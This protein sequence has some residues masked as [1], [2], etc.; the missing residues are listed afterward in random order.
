MPRK[1]KP[2][3]PP[4]RALGHPQAMVPPQLSPEEE[5]VLILIGHC[6]PGVP[7]IASP[8]GLAEFTNTALKG[9]CFTVSEKVALSATCWPPW[10]MQDAGRSLSRA[11]LVPPGAGHSEA[12]KL[13]SDYSRS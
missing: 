13:S 6:P 7:S 5:E 2:Q 4:D 1:R 12:L 8:R 3:S 11:A 10:A 9:R